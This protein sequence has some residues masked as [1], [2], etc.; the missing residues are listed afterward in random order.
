MA[1]AL[2]AEQQLALALALLQSFTVITGGP[3]T[4][5]T[6]IIVAILRCLLRMGVTVERIA[7]TAP[8]GRAAQRMSES[9][10]GQLGH[11]PARTADEARMAELS[12]P[13]HPPSARVLAL[14]QYLHLRQG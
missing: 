3:G 8:T 12:G 9:L 6:S 10:R 5:K 13:D 7:L 2:N 11:L 14:A 4:G 1:I